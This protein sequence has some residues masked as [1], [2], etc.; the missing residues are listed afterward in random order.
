MTFVISLL[1]FI[2]AIGVLV[3]VHEFGHFVTARM[4]GIRV[5]RFSVGF[6]KPLY[7][8]RRRED[9]TEYVVAALPLGGYVK[10]L[11]EREGDVAAADLPFAFNRQPLRKRFAV[12]IAGPAFNLIFALLAYWAVFMIGVPGIKPVVGDVRSGS[13]AAAAGFAK[14]DQIVSVD[15]E[16]TPTWETALLRLFEGVMQGG[17]VPVGVVTPAGVEKTLTLHVDDPRALTEPGKLLDGLGLSQW[18]PAI[19]PV[20]DKIEPGGTAAAA[21][22]QSGDKIISAGGTVVASW[23]QLVKILQASPGKTLDIVV[24][25]GGRTLA[26]GLPV[27]I[28]HTEAGKDIGHIGATVRIPAD[29]GA[30]LRAEQRYNPAVALWHAAT[31]TAGMCWL[32]LAA[33]GN[34]VLGNV[35][36][37]NLSG[38]IDIAQYAGY[39]AQGGLVPFLMFLAIVSISL[40]VL[41]LLPIPLLDGGHVL[42]YAVELVKGTPVSQQTEIIGQRVG[43]ALLLMLMIFAVYNDLSRLFN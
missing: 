30:R 34:M 12:V 15:G 22:L 21:G 43:I 39:S 28:Q 11:D 38:P 9:P 25:R 13:I 35:S 27:G 7:T 14:E 23:Q 33:A 26:L 5:L 37:H 36:W 40:G 19:P 3:T 42:Y 8:W 41:N 10:M 16:P 20:L 2:V 32:T 29:F 18:V 6:G 31:R 24:D 17:A 1:A 4:L